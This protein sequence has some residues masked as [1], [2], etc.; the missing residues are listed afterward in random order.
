MRDRFSLDQIR[1]FVA[2][3]EHGSFSAAARKLGRAQSAVSD[4][5]RRLEEE[6]GVALFD[7]TTRSPTLTGEGKL[8]LA[9]ARAIAAAAD[10]LHFRATGMKKGV[11]AELCAVMDVYFPVQA[12]AEAAADF[13]DAFP[14]TPLRL[15]VEVL[16][17]AL[18][19]VLDGRASFAVVGPT[20]IPGDCAS[21]PLYGV[22]IVMVAAPTH[23]LARIEGPITREHLAAE[24]QLVLTERDSA[25]PEREYGVLS[26]TTWRLADLY[27]K[28]AFL[29]SGL[30][31]GSM[32][33]HAIA[34]EL[35][36][37]RL[38]ILEIADAPA[39]RSPP[40]SVV[41]RAASPPG[42]AG[43]WLIERLRHADR[44]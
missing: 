30:G 40:M 28:Q 10:K 36:E 44:F 14:A 5:I 26:P 11:E 21:E 34:R 39:A 22:E 15:Y 3:A 32:P 18:R 43:R 25:A 27:A 31:W 29:L 37:G 12:M 24:V 9:D 20:P 41:Y 19:P 16:G 6:T 35:E 23:P 1:V 4:L 2:A 17:G 13:R 8:L 7:R 33:R 42:P 38:K